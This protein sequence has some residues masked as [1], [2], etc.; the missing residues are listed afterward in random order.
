MPEPSDGP[1]SIAERLSRA[2]QARDLSL[3]A[4]LLADDVTWGDVGHPRGCRNRDQVLATYGAL[5]GEGVDGRI[6]ELVEGEAGLLC[7]LAVDWPDPAARQGDRT[8]FHVYLVRDGLIAEIR[9]YD[10]RESAA[11]AAGVR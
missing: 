8:R 3:L 7:G 4:P 2:Y 1:G 6:T 5:M 11:E 9:R 10:D